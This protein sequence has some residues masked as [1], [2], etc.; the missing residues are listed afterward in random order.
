MSENNGHTAQVQYTIEPSCTSSS[1]VC[2]LRVMTLTD[3]RSF[4]FY[5]QHDLSAWSGVDALIRSSR[6]CAGDS[7]ERWSSPSGL[8]ERRPRST[9]HVLPDEFIT[10]SSARSSCSFWEFEGVPSCTAASPNPRIVLLIPDT[11]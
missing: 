1:Y 7:D 9:K 5:S 4:A 11:H 6:R 2:G 8:R 3:G 10:F